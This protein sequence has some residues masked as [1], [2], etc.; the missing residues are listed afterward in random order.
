M[1]GADSPGETASQPYKQIIKDM[2]LELNQALDSHVVV[3]VARKVQGLRI[4]E[5]LDVET[6]EGDPQAIVQELVDAFVGLSNEVV[7][8]TLRPL[9]KQ[10]PWIKLPGTKTY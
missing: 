6:L 1:T 8:K 9:L 3:K 4:S 7:V 10:C 5:T 2:L